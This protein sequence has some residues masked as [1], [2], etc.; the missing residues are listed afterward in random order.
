MRI[1][2]STIY[3]TGGSRISDLQVGLN[4]TQQQIAAGRRILTPA[5]DP[6]DS[7]R[8]LV[9]SQSDSLN[10]QFAT[11]RQAAK[12][13]LSVSESVLGNV[14]DTLHNIKALIVQAGNGTYSDTE[15]GFIA[16]E[17][18]GNLD[19]LL[20]LANSTDGTGNYLFSGFSTTVAP[21][22][23]VAG[24]AAYNG[25]QGQ[26]FLQADTSRQIP[27]SSP[28]TAIFENIRTS[29]GQFNVQS[30]P[31]NVGQA[32]ATAAINVPTSGSLTGNNYEVAFDNL[33]TSFT[34][35]NKTTGAVVVPLTPYVSGSTVTFDGI[36]LQVT[37]A[38]G[39]PVVAPGPG[40]KFSVQPGNQNIFETVTDIINALNTPANTAAAKKD[41][42]AALT[43][44]NNNVD[45]SLNNVLTARAQLGT[46]LKE[47]D[48]LDTEGDA[49]G[50]A[51]KQDLSALLD[52]DYAKAITELNQQQTTLQ[53]AQQ[54]FVKTSELSLFSYIR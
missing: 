24:G 21:Y 41:L 26:R 4:K 14:T 3:E 39:P 7:A 47:L 1:S 19:Q 36:D 34:V 33:G 6:I 38:G 23:K 31:S 9:I 12:N 48:D 43:Q 40:D 22:T 50:V 11:N 8:A 27:L 25:D 54:S 15:R 28:G 42:T 5:D 32:L 17:L 37:N 20:G 16:Q 52:L 51:Y 30:N 44:G 45:K 13:N 18:Q 46:S 29:A 35:T 53:A 49:K 2:T 10:T